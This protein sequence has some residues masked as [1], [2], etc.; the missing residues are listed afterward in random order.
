MALLIS[1]YK[2]KTYFEQSMMMYD[3][4]LIMKEG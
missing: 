4:N 2:F 3:S 1:K